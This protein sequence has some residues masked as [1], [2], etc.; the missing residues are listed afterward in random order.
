MPSRCGWTPRGSGF[1]V[2][3]TGNNIEIVKSDGTT[4]PLGIAE[5]C[6]GMRMVVAFIALAGSVALLSCHLWWQRT[7]VMLLAVPVAVLM[8]LV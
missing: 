2:S 4:I 6:S 3:L 8:N 5:A 1:T 7:A